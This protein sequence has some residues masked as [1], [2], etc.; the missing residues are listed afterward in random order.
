LP[1]HYFETGP[2]IAGNLYGVNGDNQFPLS[3][4]D[5]FILHWSYPQ[6][7]DVDDTKIINNNALTNTVVWVFGDS[8]ADALKP[9]F[10]ASYKEV[11]FFKFYEFDRVISSSLSKP[12]L[13]IWVTVDNNFTGNE[14]IS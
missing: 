8:F 3:E 13:V 11:H 5:N 14:W 10:I 9:Y 12:N 1:S 4:G 7:F 2:V 6:N